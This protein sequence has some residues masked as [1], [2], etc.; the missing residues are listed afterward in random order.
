MLVVALAAGVVGSAAI[1]CAITPVNPDGCRKIEDARCDAVVSC[2]TYPNFDVA[3]CKRFYRDQCLH[4]LASQTDP[5]EPLL[6]ACVSAIQASGACA[7]AGAA[8][9]NAGPS[10]PAV[11]PCDLLAHPEKYGECSFLAPPAAPVVDAATEA[12]AATG[13]GG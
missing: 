1:G 3:A 10:S 4:G 8:T 7:K 11:A 13:D 9:C 2:S 12:E 5:G 6:N